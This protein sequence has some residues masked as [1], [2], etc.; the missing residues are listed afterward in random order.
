MAT[1]TNLDNILRERFL[2]AV[3]DYFTKLDEEVLVVKSNEIAIP[4]LDSEGN[5]K[6]MVI[7]FKVPKGSRDG[8]AYDGYSMKEA[9]D[10]ATAEKAE[11]AKESARKKAE[12][13]AKDKAR[14]EKKEEGE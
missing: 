2:N 7:T 11:K 5:E 12:K 10:L 9:F 1:K 6:W 14:R 4:C 8:D 13:I 3:K